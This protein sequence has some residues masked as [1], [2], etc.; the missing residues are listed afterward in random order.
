VGASCCWAARAQGRAQRPRML[1]WRSSWSARARSWTRRA[2]SR[3]RQWAS[4]RRRC[5][6][7]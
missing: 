7:Y 1:R 6:H 4:C 3:P 2:A 5:A